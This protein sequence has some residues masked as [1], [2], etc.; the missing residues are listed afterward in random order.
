MTNPTFLSLLSLCLF[1]GLSLNCKQDILASYMLRGSTD[2]DTK[3]VLCKNITTNCCSKFDQ[4][5]LHKYFDTVF[6]KD[7]AKRLGDAEKAFGRISTVFKKSDFDYTKPL[8][9][10]LSMGTP[11]DK[12]KEKLTALAANL[13]ATKTE[14]LQKLHGSVKDI[15]KP[16]NDIVISVR[17][18]FM[19]AICDAEAHKYI[20]Y[21]TGAVTYSQKF[22]DKLADN[23]K[24]YLDFVANKY[25]KLVSYVLDYH[26]F[27]FL[28]TDI[29][30]ITDKDYIFA[31][32][33]NIDSINTCK[34]GG[35]PKACNA[36]CSEFKL[37]S[38]TNL[39]DGEITQFDEFLKNYDAAV[40]VFNDEA[41]Y[42]NNFKFTAEKGVKNV[43]IVDQVK[44]AKDNKGPTDPAA[45]VVPK[46]PTVNGAS[47]A[48]KDPSTDPTLGLDKIVSTQ[49]P[50]ADGKAFLTKNPIAAVTAANVD[51]L[52]TQTNDLYNKFKAAKD[53]DANVKG[54]D[55]EIKAFTAQFDFYLY[56][57]GQKKG[58][59]AVVPPVAG[60][61]DPSTNPAMSLDKIVSTLGPLADGKAFL[62]K[63]PISTATATNVDALLT[64][65]ND[66]YNKFKAAKDTDANVKGKDIEIT[67]FVGQFDF[68]IS[69]LNKLKNSPPSP[70]GGD[71]SKGS[72]GAQK[73]RLADLRALLKP[74]KQI[75]R[76]SNKH[77]RFNERN[78]S[79]RG[80]KKRYFVPV[81]K[82]SRRERRLQDKAPVGGTP[83]P[84]PSDGKDP[85][86]KAK[87]AY[88]PQ[89]IQLRQNI[90]IDSQALKIKSDAFANFM[91]GRSVSDL[92]TKTAIFKDV[93]S[94]MNDLDNKH[95]LY[96]LA[97]KPRSMVDLR[98]DIDVL[99]VNITDYISSDYSLNKN[100]LLELLWYK[101]KAKDIV[102]GIQLDPGVTARLQK[103]IRQ[104]V[105]WFANDVNIRYKK[106]ISPAK[107]QKADDEENQRLADAAAAAASDGSSD[108]SKKAFISSGPGGL[109]G[110]AKGVGRL[111][112]VFSVVL[113]YGLSL[114]N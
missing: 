104:Q 18:G 88:E 93:K 66:I 16:M 34:K 54:K 70:S 50:L 55:A 22:C 13:N 42:K 100:Q 36:F 59:G 78:L 40:A 9:Y 83:P 8:N 101:P 33:K 69:G 96:R 102:A 91:A 1:I 79:E 11:K 63:N 113:I 65:A 68:Y 56:S 20:N 62:I 109:E 35:D 21:D 10:F 106:F 4:M 25:A 46:D 15:Y 27:Y 94:N 89:H 85:K 74:K 75:A 60:P 49:G 58:S 76:R 87:V 48:V 84:A 29:S 43:S 38:F 97:S 26:Y 28:L 41:N 114:L 45:P 47:N 31:T 32:R 30:M 95:G 71:G 24:G 64:Q 92:I 72:G 67:A 7:V 80:H 112:V 110:D 61:V 53:T 3:N 52:T 105:S 44:A 77:H 37:N 111:A 12:V 98:C 51:S 73:R 2:P 57:L 39:F 5:K 103:T 99:G 86:P 82:R 81:H 90:D 23:S 14:D 107:F 108:K 17:N 19:C 6:S